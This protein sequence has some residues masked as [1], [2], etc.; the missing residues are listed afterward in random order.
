MELARIVRLGLNISVETEIFSYT[1][2]GTAPKEVLVRIDL[3]DAAGPIAGD[4]PYT[5]TIY[6]NGVPVSP[7]ASVQVAAGVIRTVMISKAL[8]LELGDVLSLRVLG[9]GT[10]VNVNA[11]ISIR[12]ITPLRAAEFLGSGSVLVD[13]N[14]GGPDALA[15]KAANGMGVND[16]DIYVYLK[17]DYDAGRRGS[18]YVLARTKTDVSGRWIQPVMLDHETYTLICFKQGYYGPDRM[19]VVVA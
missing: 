5:L 12:D 16:A 8:P 10:D 6:I 1:Y 13:H 17:A 14:Y 15:Y 3:G 4:A 2:G 19:D 9:A 11:I 18:D 7:S